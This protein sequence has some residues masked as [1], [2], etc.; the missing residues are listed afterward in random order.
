MVVLLGGWPYVVAAY[1]RSGH[2]LWRYATKEGELIQDMTSVKAPDGRGEFVALAHSGASP[3]L[4]LLDDK[5]KRLWC[6][7]GIAMRWSVVSFDC[8]GDGKDDVVAE[9][10]ESHPYFGNKLACYS[11]AGRHLRD[12]DVTDVPT[13]A[14]AVDFD[15]DGR[16][17]VAGQ[18]HDAREGP[19]VL[20]AWDTQGRTLGELRVEESNRSLAPVVGARLESSAAGHAVTVT[21]GWIVGFSSTRGRWGQRIPQGDFPQLAAADLDGDGRDE[22]ITESGLVL[23]AWSWDGVGRSAS[24]L[25]AH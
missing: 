4:C 18:Y 3:G 1:E 16:A 7:D 22:L 17:D 11:T 20:A 9:S 21:D 8:D 6:S 25:P 14:A 15:G 24:T 5:G 19:L 13:R 23:S 2:Q 12:L 10:P